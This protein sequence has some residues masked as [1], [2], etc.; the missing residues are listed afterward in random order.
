M[1]HTLF[2]FSS[3]WDFYHI[4]STMLMQACGI[5]ERP[6]ERRQTMILYLCET[7]GKWLDMSLTKFFASAFKSIPK[8]EQPRGVA[9]P[10]GC[11]LMHQVQATDKLCLVTD[12]RS[13]ASGHVEFWHDGRKFRGE[14]FEVKE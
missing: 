10:N 2:S 7:C 3:I 11:G 9:C 1:L 8:I 14:L 6:K 5:M 13:N 4:R 12:I